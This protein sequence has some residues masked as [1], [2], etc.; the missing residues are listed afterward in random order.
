VCPANISLGNGCYT[1]KGDGTCSD[2][3]HFDFDPYMYGGA[4]CPKHVVGCG[5]GCQGDVPEDHDGNPI[6][7]QSDGGTCPCASPILIDTS[8]DGFALTDFAGGV[9]F[10]LDANGSRGRLSWTAVSSDD[11]WLAL[12]RN[13][14][15]VIDDGRELFGNNT[16]QPTPPT[17]QSRNGFLA[18]SEFD[19][20]SAGG[21]AD[22]VIDSHDA[23]FFSLR[24]W[25]DTNHDGV[26]QASELRT[27][28]ESDVARIHLEYK[29]SKRTDAYGNRF[30]YRAKI[31]DAKGAKVGRWAWDVFLLSK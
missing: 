23:V 18:L 11:A 7:Q 26:S 9:L 14:N 19:K 16:P 21:K 3:D 25:Q 1:A 13:G 2:P 5:E 15:G 28:M 30:R 29:E 24:L 22:G 8:G 17:G 31:D 27:L 10:D 6:G 4:C 20:P 12:D